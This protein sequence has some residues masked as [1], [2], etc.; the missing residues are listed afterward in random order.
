MPRYETAEHRESEYAF[1]ELMEGLGWSLW[2]VPGWS[3]YDFIAYH[4]FR[5]LWCAVEFKKL[6]AP[7]T[8]AYD[9]HGG[10]ALSKLKVDKIVPLTGWFD[11]VLYCVQLNAGLYF[12]DIRRAQRESEVTPFK[13]TKPRPGFTAPAPHDSELAYRIPSWMFTEIKEKTCSA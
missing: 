7:T 3:C 9:H 12:A 13:R 4:L 11:H 5:D 8:D 2:K 10:L 1:S 6:S